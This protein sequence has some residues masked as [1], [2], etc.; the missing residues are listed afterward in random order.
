MSF[1][2]SIQACFSITFSWQKNKTLLPL[3]ACLHPTIEEWIGFQLEAR[4]E[5]R[6]IFDVVQVKALKIGRKRRKRS[7]RAWIS[8]GKQAHFN[9]L[10]SS[11]SS[12]P[13][14]AQIQ[15][16][17]FSQLYQLTRCLIARSPLNYLTPGRRLSRMTRNGSKSIWPFSSPKNWKKT[18]KRLLCF[19]VSLSSAKLRLF[20]FDSCWVFFSGDGHCSSW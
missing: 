10:L 3:L 1:V 20:N 6:E 7:S 19:N 5:K 14:K 8:G 4:V 17:L 13:R 18:P 12:L 15:S 16:S 11:F 2:I 9:S